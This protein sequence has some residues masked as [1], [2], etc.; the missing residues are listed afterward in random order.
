MEKINSFKDLMAWQEGHKLVLMIYE[1]TKFFPKDEMFGLISQMRRAAVSITSNVAEGFSRQSYKEKLQFYAIANGSATELQNQ[2]EVSKD[3]GYLSKEKYDTAY[4]LSIKIHKIINGLIKGYRLRI[5]SPV[6]PHSLFII[7][8][9]ISLFLIPNSTSAATLAK[10]SNFLALNTG[11]VGWWT[12]DGPKMLTNVA[13]S[14]GQGNNGYLQ[15][16][17]STTTVPG[18]LGQAL[19]FDGS[20]DYVDRGTG[21]TSVN[22]IAFWVYPKTTTEYFINLT[23]TTDYIWLNAGTVTATGLADPT[24]YVNGVVS[25]V[26]SANQWQYVVVTTGTAENASNFDI[27]RTQ[28]ANYLEGNIDDVRVY[29]RALSAGE[30]Q[31][32]YN[33]G[34]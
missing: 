29:S 23:S 22:T 25:S 3:V 30:I 28:D 12:F 7:L 1:I 15:G 27:G 31:Q 26:L 11:L 8:F 20:N 19:A 18:K 14:S 9:F 4:A 16:Q 2:L 21:P 32:L 10:P 34:R 13:D 6:I 33:M 5:F 24:I 17:T